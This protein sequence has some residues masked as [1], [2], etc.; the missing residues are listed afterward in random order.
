M[1]IGNSKIHRA[2]HGGLVSLAGV[3]GRARRLRLSWSTGVAAQLGVPTAQQVTRLLQ[4]VDLLEGRVAAL[5]QEL[6]EFQG[7]AQQ[8]K[9]GA[10]Q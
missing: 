7:A 5:K 8:C 3:V 9:T 2:G 1:A 4:R 10:V 6:R